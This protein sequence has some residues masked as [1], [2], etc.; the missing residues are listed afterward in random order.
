MGSKESKPIIINTQPKSLACSADIPPPPSLDKVSNLKSGPQI[1]PRAVFDTRYTWKNGEIGQITIAFN[2]NSGAWSWLGNSSSDGN[3]SMN[4]GWTDP[5]LE[6]FEIDGYV[7]SKDLYANEFRLGCLIYPCNVGDTIQTSDG[8]TLECMGSNN[9]C[10]EG[11]EPGSVVLH[12]FGHA[13]A[14]YHEH[15]NFIDGNPLVFDLDG[16]TLFSLSQ[17]KGVCDPCTQA[18]CRKLC[19]SDERR[20]VWCG[21]TNYC[22]SSS[23]TCNVNEQISSSCQAD[24][25]EARDDAQTNV[26]NRYECTDTNC[27][28]EGSFFDPDSVMIY[29]ISDYMLTEDSPNPTKTNYKL[30]STD[31]AWLSRMYPINNTNPPQIKIQFDGGQ[32]WQRYWVKKVVTE[33]ISPHVGI[34]FTFDLE[35]D[36]DTG[37]GGG[38]TSFL[39]IV[40]AVLFVVLLISMIP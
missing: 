24:I 25:N 8:R 20:P 16:C 35:G 21:N 31:I 37:E 9:V 22:P 14:M 13:L 39:W 17:N 27:P 19:F 34:M 26:L 29:S 23:G 1:A 3:P 15:Q 5:P 11:W 7:F 36:P 32:D 30:S 4:L 12:E 40:L 10:V 18:Y 2:A 38:S 33:K 28:Y 6:D